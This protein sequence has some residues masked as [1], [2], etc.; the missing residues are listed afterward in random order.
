MYVGN[1]TSAPTALAVGAD[2]EIL[3]G[4][5]GADCS[6]LAASTDGKVLTAHTGGAPTWETASGGGIA[7]SIK[8]TDLNPMVV[9]NG[10]IANKAGL[11]LLRFLLHV[12]LVKS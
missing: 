6:W 1:G 5:T 2:G 12:R 10:Y 11:L 3:I 8:T 9:D 4:T 7:W